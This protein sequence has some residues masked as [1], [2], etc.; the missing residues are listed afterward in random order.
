M[1]IQIGAGVHITN[2]IH[3]AIVRAERDEIDV[4][5]DFNGI[6]VRATPTSTEREVMAEYNAECDRRRQA[7]LL[8]PEYAAAQARAASEAAAK[9]ARVGTLRTFPL[10]AALTLA[11][12]CVWDEYAK[13]KELAQWLLNEDPGSVGMAIMAAALRREVVARYPHIGL[14]ERHEMPTGKGDAKR[15]LDTQIAVYGGTVEFP[16]GCISDEEQAASLVAV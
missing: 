8:S 15:C 13:A 10:H 11:T 7:Y 3:S 9:R 4:S 16:C 14:I 5:F 12:G 2:A 1:E 6:K